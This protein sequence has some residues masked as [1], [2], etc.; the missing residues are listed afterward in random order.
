MGTPPETHG[1]SPIP[2]ADLP[3]FEKADFFT[4]MTFLLAR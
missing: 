4:Q 2:D 3:V 1:V